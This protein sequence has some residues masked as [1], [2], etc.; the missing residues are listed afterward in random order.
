MSLFL[1]VVVILSALA[2]FAMEVARDSLVS[3]IGNHSVQVA[4]TAASSIDSTI[5]LKRHEMWVFGNGASVQN[6]L[7]IS[8][9][10][11]D[12][13]DDR[14]EYIDA[15][16]DEWSSTPAGETTPLMDQIL[17][18]NISTRISEV[19]ME[20][21][22]EEHGISIYS[23]VVVTNKYGAVVG[24]HPRVQD[25]RLNDAPW[26]SALMQ[27]KTFY[28]NV[29]YNPWLDLHGMT[30]AI[31]LSDMDGAYS[32][33]MIA[34]I[35]VV[36]VIE[37]AVYLGRPFET[38]ELHIINS[39]GL[40]IFSDGAF[41]VFE[42]V[43]GEG[44][45]T[46]I[47]GP[48]GY[49]LLDEGGKEKLFSFSRTSGYQ[50]YP[51][52]E[53]IVV[54][55]HQTAEVLSSVDDLRMNVLR[56]AIPVLL[57]AVALSYIFALTI[58]RRVR[59]VADA[60]E[61]FSKGRLD[62]RIGS[63]GSDEIGQL[64]ESFDHMADELSGLYAD[65]E[66]KV[67]ERTRELNVANKKLRLL[68]SITRHDALNQV[69]IITGWISVAEEG[70]T[71]KEQLETLR[72]IKEAAVNLGANLEFTGLY[73]KVGVK[74]PEWVDMDQ[75][76][77]YSLF[78]MGPREFE[79]HNGFGDLQVYCDPMI[80]NVLRNLVDNS[81]RHGGEITRISFTYQEVPDGLVIVCEDDGVG[82]PVEIKENLFEPGK[83]SGGRKSFGLYLTK[84]ILAI[85][86]ITIRETGEP[87]KGA[88]FEM[89]VPKDGYRFQRS[90]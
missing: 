69:S 76:L 22:L 80:Q 75:A 53:W 62:R 47:S 65:L 5:Y 48:S 77:T 59:T 86:G 83:G 43:S 85:T 81:V 49:F 74:K 45:F 6:E 23:S 32:G 52:N 18:N 68:G 51:G 28:G 10:E 55:D 26:W 60:A 31:T 41:H 16:D 66:G 84:E 36:S 89:H 1:T 63:M 82:V 54:V 50:S 25:Y 24:M 73:E 90:A 29:E 34:F 72:K 27:I 88:R 7:T 19:L 39:D 12:T 71:G 42:N 64:S 61:E 78:G 70:T 57:L 38:T 56:V 33:T 87:G 79:L 35:D 67:M 9:E 17:S 58:S 3:S 11:F 44:Y 8:N 37:E 4:D 15:I 14:E 13:M 30:I 2:V 46:L 40:L 20:H 21:Y